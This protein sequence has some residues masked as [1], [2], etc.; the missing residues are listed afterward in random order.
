M[1][2]TGLA[3]LGLCFPL[4]GQS[5]SS[6]E[7]ASWTLSGDKKAWWENRWFASGMYRALASV[8]DKGDV[9]ESLLIVEPE[10][11]DSRVTSR[12]EALCPSTSDEVRK[13][14]SHNQQFLALR[15]GG[16]WMLSRG[17]DEAPKSPSKPEAGLPSSLR[18]LGASAE[19]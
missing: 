17:F 6:L 5:R 2:C 15:C 9:V 4:P 16:G 19:K 14:R 11:E 18:G 10:G 12:L 3:I 8:F 1:L 13:C 7:D